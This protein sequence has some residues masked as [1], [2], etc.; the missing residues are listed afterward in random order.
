MSYPYQIESYEAYQS[1]WKQS[2]EDPEGFWGEVA[3]HFLWR[4]KWDKVLS[5]NFRDPD[6]KWFE[7]G[8]LNITENCLDRHLERYGNYPA[9]IWEPNHPDEHHRVL[10]YQQLHFKVNQFAHVLHNN[11]V[12]KG[13]RVCIYMGMIPELAIAVLACGAGIGVDP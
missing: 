13:D 3:E 5:W 11:G 8:R 2:V 10:T 7:G 9:I 4:R 12:R 6:V 1:A